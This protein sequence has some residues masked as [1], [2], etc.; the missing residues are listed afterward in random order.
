MQYLVKWKGW[1]YRDLN[2]VEHSWLA[3]RYQSRLSKFLTKGSTVS[4]EPTKEELGEEQDEVEPDAKEAA[5]AAQTEDDPVGPV[6]DADIEE[7][8]PAA[9]KV[10]DR[11]IDVVYTSPLSGKEIRI[12]DW[13]NR[14]ADDRE[15]V[16]HVKRA[17]MKWCGLAYDQ[18]KSRTAPPLDR[19]FGVVPDSSLLPRS[20]Q[21][22]SK[23]PR[24][25]ETTRTTVSSKLTKHTSSRHSARC[26][27]LD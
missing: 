4:F 6:P 14:P 25:R 23:S 19:A 26:A 8:I 24:K 7:R 15:S 16:K 12:K 22:P 21:R 10:V 3:A 27:S 17:Y 18:C 1:S 9:W 5:A 13:R 20:P 11:V 2:W